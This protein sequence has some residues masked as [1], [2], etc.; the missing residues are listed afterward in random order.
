MPDKWAVMMA[1]KNEKTDEVNT[2][3]SGNLAL[4]DHAEAVEEHRQTYGGSGTLWAK[5]K[6]SSTGC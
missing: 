5:A 1:S 6:A 3:I 2:Q 4:V